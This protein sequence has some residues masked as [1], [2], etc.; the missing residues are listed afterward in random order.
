MASSRLKGMNLQSHMTKVIEERKNW[1]QQR[2]LAQVMQSDLCVRSLGGHVEGGLEGK[3]QAQI[4]RHE[5]NKCPRTRQFHNSFLYSTYWDLARSGKGGGEGL[6][7][8]QF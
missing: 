4:F 2:T 8:V 1:V 7:F 6:S 3:M 5:L